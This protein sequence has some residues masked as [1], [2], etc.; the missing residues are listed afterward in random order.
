[1]RHFTLVQYLYQIGAD[2]DNDEVGNLI[3]PGPIAGIP[4]SRV[5]DMRHRYERAQI[6]GFAF[7]DPEIAEKSSWDIA[8]TN[9]GNRGQ[10]SETRS[11]MKVIRRF[12]S[13]IE[14]QLVFIFIKYMT[15]QKQLETNFLDRWWKG[16]RAHSNFFH[17]V[18]GHETK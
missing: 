4:W 5:A 8:G 13:T 7:Q 3:D 12:I 10:K 11:T 14:L 2:Y 16:K 1:M 18:D 6:P 15:V 9:T 17:S